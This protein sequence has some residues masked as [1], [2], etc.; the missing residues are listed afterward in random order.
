MPLPVDEGPLGIHEVELVVQSGPGLGDGSGVGQHADSALDLGQVT[1][2]DDGGR[3]V[4][5]ANL[6][7]K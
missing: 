6:K 4:V 5:D 2:G 1:A 3:L 7:I